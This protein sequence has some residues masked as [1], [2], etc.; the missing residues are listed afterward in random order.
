MEMNNVTVIVGGCG[1]IGSNLLKC[2]SP[3]K[4]VVVVDDLSLGS[5]RNIQSEL[6]K[7]NI[8]LLI[9]DISEERGATKLESYLRGS[10][11]V[12]VWHLAANS[13]IPSGVKDFKVDL[14]K[15]FLTTFNLL[16]L[17]KRSG[18]CSTFNFASSS[19]VY[20][21]HG[22]KQISETTAPLL[23]ISNYGAMKLAS[24]ALISAARGLSFKKA[25]IF[26]FPNVV[27]APA[28]H[29][30]VY[31]L[32]KKLSK[33]GNELEVLGDGTQRKSYLHVEWLID[34]MRLIVERSEEEVQIINIGNDDD[35]ISV[36]RIAELVV[37]NR[38]PGCKIKYGYADRGWRGDVPKF[39][40]NISKLRQ[41]GWSP[42]GTSE[43]AVEKSILEII[44]QDLGD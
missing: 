1:F 26:R 28:T 10:N 18:G 44:D 37:A 5:R 6:T 35:G 15:T 19:A 42:P 4:R 2:I 32:L 34:A 27:G 21:D 36:K 12:D 20:G 29:G 3:T 17:I 31:D 7:P 39:R 14:K 23:P 11:I 38:A 24:E 30:I 25:N 43:L 41:K 16:E 8:D 33:N 13:D 9:A 40:Y 22:E